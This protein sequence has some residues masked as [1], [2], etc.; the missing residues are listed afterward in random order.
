M[1][2]V[3]TASEAGVG[4]RQT[5]NIS[6]PFQNVRAGAESFGA[7]TGRSIQR[8]G[9]SVGQ[10]GVMMKRVQDEEDRAKAYETYTLASEQS[11]S[12][13]NDPEKGIYQRKGSN[14]LGSYK[15]SLRGIDDI[16]T[17]S[18]EG[19]SNG[20]RAR[21]DQLWRAKRERM[22]EGVSRFEVQ[23]RNAFK[24]Q[25]AEASLKT[26]IND[27]VENFNNPAYV[28]ESVKTGEAIIKDSMTGAPQ[29]AVDLK[30]KEFRAGI[31]SAVIGRMVE[32][33]PLGAKEYYEKNKDNILPSQKVAIEKTLDDGE[34]RAAAQTASQQILKNYPTYIEQKK[35]VGQIKND[36]VR[37]EVDDIIE[38]HQS[39]QVKIT[40]DRQRELSGE[41][42]QIALDTND[43]NQI[44]INQ[45]AALDEDT[46][47]QIKIYTQNGSGASKTDPQRWS[48]L[49]TMYS[50]NPQEFKKV[51]LSNEIN[52]LSESDFKDFVKKQQELVSGNNINQ[53]KVRTYNQIA[54]DRLAAVGIST[55]SSASDSDAKKTAIFFRALTDEI[56]VFTEQN[57]K[58]PNNQQVEDIIDKLLIKGVAKESDLGTGRFGTDPAFAFQGAKSFVA[59]DVDDIPVRERK[60]AIAALEQIG[61]QPTEENILKLVN[62]KLANDQK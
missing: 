57:N 34:F 2:K 60:K 13:L 11:R 31:H 38:T 32:D 16:Y 39:E 33:D 7:G 54:N 10:F 12:F 50:Q 9:Q 45:W 26:S 23:Q 44:P 46:K 43:P 41:A 1:V 62:K 27:A 35:A 37:A 30:V 3:P 15:D 17:K 22:L 14:A 47:K 19:L 48:D 59:D 21:F 6:T 18:T 40:E 20:A 52:N 29:E 24:Q 8:V 49:Y 55:T 58:E 56:T 51:N 25:S 36:K 28:D 53:V 4:Q 5:N 61:A 42:W